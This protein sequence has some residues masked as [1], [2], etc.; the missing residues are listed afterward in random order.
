M[1]GVEEMKIVTIVGARPQFI[2]AAAV[3]R[4]MQAHNQRGPSTGRLSSEKK[5]HEI[6]VHTG[7]HYDYLMDR[8][9]FEE[10]ELPR[11]DYHLG[12]GSGSH[13]RQTGTM[14]ERIETVLERERPEMVLVYGDT[15]STLA[16]ALAAAK[17][18]I[19]VAHV[20]SGLR[21]YNRSMPEEINRLITDHLATLLF[22]PTPQSVRN[23]EKEGIKDGRTTSVRKVG[24]V[25]YDSIL[26][27]SKLAEKK[28]TILK[29]LNLCSS[30]PNSE[31]RTQNYYLA[32]LHRA[33]NTDDPKRLKSILKALS[34]IGRKMP[35]VLPLH[36]RTRKMMKTYGLFPKS[37][38]IRWIEPVS[39]LNMLSLEKNAK[40]I[41]TDSGGVQKE[42]YWLKVPCF[43]LR[44]ETEWVE[45]A[46]SGWN[47]LVGTETRRI[48]EEVSRLEK[49]KRPLSPPRRIGVFGE[50]KASERI[51]EILTRRITPSSASEKRRSSV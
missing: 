38:E 24:D 40:A 1:S 17:L 25:M 46:R 41:L 30:T 43:T 27:Y 26:Y 31:L 21:S 28:S 5:I 15:N 13:A 8:V 7:Q 42:A 20:E 19:P 10:L 37:R 49:R 50:G 47:V 22:C 23:L 16:G 48:V 11:P 35:V 39:Y 36:P 6:F 45:T 18:N 12:V 33:E 14:L 4:A 34:E 9:F 3:S 51:V 32:T 29:D 2:K 44:E